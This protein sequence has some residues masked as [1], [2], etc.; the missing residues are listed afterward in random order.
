MANMR[1]REVRRLI[2][3]AISY[4][5]DPGD[6]HTL[7]TDDATWTAVVTLRDAGI[8][9]TFGPSEGYEYKDTAPCP[10]VKQGDTILSWVYGD[11]GISAGGMWVSGEIMRD[12]PGF[13]SDPH[14][15][16]NP[17]KMV[18]CEVMLESI[19]DW[20]KGEGEE[21]E[22]LRH[23]LFHTYEWW[24]VSPGGGDVDYRPDESI[25]EDYYAL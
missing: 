11:A 7:I 21:E 3:E 23:V 12:H 22:L 13:S 24:L 17:M 18:S 15:R 6:G 2:V 25:P 8:L 9:P 20:D 19:I 5:V 14:L 4:R 10:P 1:V 16:R